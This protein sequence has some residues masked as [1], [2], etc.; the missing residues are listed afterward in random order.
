MYGRRARATPASA[1]KAVV[2]LQNG[3]IRVG[4]HHRIIRLLDLTAHLI[5]LVLGDQCERTDRNLNDD[6]RQPYPRSGAP[7]PRSAGV[8]G[9]AVPSTTCCHCANE[10][11]GDSDEGSSPSAFASNGLPP[12]VT[13]RTRSGRSQTRYS[14][15][16]VDNGTA[17]NPLAIGFNALKVRHVSAECR[18]GGQVPNEVR[19][20]ARLP[21]S[22]SADVPRHLAGSA[23][24]ALE[25][26]SRTGRSQAVPAAPWSGQTGQ[27]RQSPSFEIARIS[28]CSSRR[29]ENSAW[30]CTKLSSALIRVATASASN[31]QTARSSK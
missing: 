22:R 2:D 20:L 31:S 9:S 3:A 24:F 14:P 25:Q 7:R 28:C 8:H 17:N 12:H 21:M 26:Q 30:A 4:N 1:S 11:R 27:L 10:R 23:Y 15:G 13:V 18:R 5:Q 19:G 16:M 29:T 6:I